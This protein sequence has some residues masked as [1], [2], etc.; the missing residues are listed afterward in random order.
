MP[1][2][3]ALYF[4]FGVVVVM[5]LVALWVTMAPGVKKGKHGHQV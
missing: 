3:A 4:V 5:S 2:Y 1:N